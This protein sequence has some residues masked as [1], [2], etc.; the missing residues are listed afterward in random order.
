MAGG[1]SN[2]IYDLVDSY[3]DDSLQH[4]TNKQ[5]QDGASGL[6]NT[7]VSAHNDNDLDIITGNYDYYSDITSSPTDATLGID[8]VSDPIKSQVRD[9]NTVF[10]FKNSYNNKYIIVY[11]KKA[12]VF[13]TKSDWD[14]AMISFKWRVG[15]EAYTSSDN[16]NS[17]MSQYSGSLSNLLTDDQHSQ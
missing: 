3:T 13:D 15:V 8:V 6:M 5:I 10:N 14:N 7:L 11:N 1:I 2:K 17:V 12:F 16:N 4:V 9:S